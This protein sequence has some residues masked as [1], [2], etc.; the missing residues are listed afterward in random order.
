MEQLSLISVQINGEVNGK[1]T[2]FCVQFYLFVSF[3]F[4]GCVAQGWP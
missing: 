4:P 1:R 3:S 2:F